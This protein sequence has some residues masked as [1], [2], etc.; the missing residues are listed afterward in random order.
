MKNP[1][2]GFKVELVD[3]SNLF[4]WNVYIAGPPGKLFTTL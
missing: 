1:V 2:G 4:E 3:E